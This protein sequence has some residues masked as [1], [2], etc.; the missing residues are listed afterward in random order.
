[1]T[2]PSV[3]SR[4]LARLLTGARADICQVPPVGCVGCDCALF[5]RVATSAASSTELILIICP[6]KVVKESNPLRVR[7]D[8][9]LT[10]NNLSA[11]RAAI[12]HKDE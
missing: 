8:A 1:M 7:A 3:S 11:I 4:G 10:V 9:S 5:G 2:V 12:H 6:S